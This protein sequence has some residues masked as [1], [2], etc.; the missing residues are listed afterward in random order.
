MEHFDTWETAWFCTC[1]PLDGKMAILSLPDMLL[2]AKNYFW[3][4]TK[5]MVGNLNQFFLLRG[6]EEMSFSALLLFLL[7]LLLPSHDRFF[8]WSQR[9]KSTNWHKEGR[10]VHFLSL[11]HHSKIIK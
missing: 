7:P 2:V 9:K 8:A 1:A 6:S 4:T 3:E 10:L 11:Y 5:M